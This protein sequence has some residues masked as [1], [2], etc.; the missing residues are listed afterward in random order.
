MTRNEV[1]YNEYNFHMHASLYAILYAIL[2]LDHLFLCA[3]YLIYLIKILHH[4]TFTSYF[5]DQCTQ[6][7]DTVHILDYKTDMSFTEHSTVLY[8]SD[9]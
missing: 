9:A 5:T 6:S 8:S 4:H 7:T 2:K 1:Q 3:L